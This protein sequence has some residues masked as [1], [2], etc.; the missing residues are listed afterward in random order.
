MLHARNGERFAEGAFSRI[1]VMNRSREQKLSLDAKKFGSTEI[2]AP[3]A[4]DCDPFFDRSQTL[5]NISAA[6]ARISKGCEQA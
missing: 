5:A 4:H 6:G 1:S 3:F 2:L